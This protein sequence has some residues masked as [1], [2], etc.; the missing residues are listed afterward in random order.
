MLAQIA[1]EILNIAHFP[2]RNF[3][4]ASV[5]D[6]RRDIHLRRLLSHGYKVRTISSLSQSRNADCLL[7]WHHRA[8]G[9]SGIEEGWRQPKWALRTSLDE[10]VHGCH[11]RRSL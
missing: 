6:H 3:I 7:G 11:V 5:P 9:N 8:D 4:T 10:Y 1:S 2:D